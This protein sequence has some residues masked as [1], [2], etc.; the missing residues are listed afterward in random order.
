MSH[1][2][3]RSTTHRLGSSTNPRLASGSFTTDNSMFC[4]VA[5]SAGASPV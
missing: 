2:K 1:P 5:A 4:F 3:L